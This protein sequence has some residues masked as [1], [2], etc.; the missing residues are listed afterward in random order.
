MNRETKKIKTPSGY[1]VVLNCWLTGGERQAINASILEGKEISPAGFSLQDMKLDGADL[2]K[3]QNAQLKQYVVGVKV[4]GK[5]VE[6]DLLETM[7]NWKEE[8]YNSVSNAVNELGKG[9]TESPKE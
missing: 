3:V 9:E 2:M 7:L 5:D 8:D 1:E 6:G 4:D